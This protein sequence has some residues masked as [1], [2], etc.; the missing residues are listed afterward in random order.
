MKKIHQTI[1][2]PEHSN[3]VQA[4][5]ASLFELP[6]EDAPKFVEYN[7]TQFLEMW[8][9]IRKQNY[10]YTGILYN[11]RNGIKQGTATEQFVDKFNTIKEMKGVNGYF[12]AL[13][14][15]PKQYNKYDKIPI[16]HPV[17]IDKD[18]NIVYDVDKDNVNVKY[19]EADEIGYNGIIQIWNINPKK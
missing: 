16:T 14:Y 4:T 1:F 18:F 11:K 13:V 17:I 9:F 19:P 12:Y 8:S 15:S 10:K 5:F 6:L 3:C 7:D 2:D